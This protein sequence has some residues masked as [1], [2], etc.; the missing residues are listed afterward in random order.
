[1]SKKR[2]G[3]LKEILENLILIAKLLHE[4]AQLIKELFF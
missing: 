3:K 1:M 4:L 2:K